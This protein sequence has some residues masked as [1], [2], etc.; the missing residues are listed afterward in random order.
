MIRAESS[1]AAGGRTGAARRRA[2]TTYRLSPVDAVAQETHFGV[3]RDQIELDFV[4]SH[5][6]AVLAGLRDRF[7]F[8]GGTA[9][10]RTILDG[11]RLSEDIDML[12]VGQSGCRQ[13]RGR[14]AVPKAGAWLRRAE[15]RPLVGP[16]RERH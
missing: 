7:I 16:G 1:D 3:A 4:I 10:S 15:G 6:L 13:G 12:S 11:L 5:V 14:R 9:L 8:Y 2:D